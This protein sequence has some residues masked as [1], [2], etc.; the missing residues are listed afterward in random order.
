TLPRHP[1]LGVLAER[2]FHT[3]AE[4]FRADG[5]LPIT[6]FSAP[7]PLGEVQEIARQVKRLVLEEGYRPAEIALVVRER[8]RYGPLIQRVFSAEGIPCG[9][10]PRP[11]LPTIPAVKAALK[12]LDARA[13]WDR[14]EPFQALLKN[15]YVESFCRIP[16]DAADNALV[17]VGLRISTRDWLDR[18]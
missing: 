12:I 14:I 1:V 15:D 2:L 13:N 5:P 8:D 11:P 3:E 6:I 7:H 16:R 10:D 4:A 17:S 18:A 9:L